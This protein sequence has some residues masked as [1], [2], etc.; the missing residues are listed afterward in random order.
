M[1]LAALTRAVVRAASFLVPRNGRA[2][3]IQEWEAELTHRLQGGDIDA[4]GAFRLLWRSAGALPHALWHLREAWR[5]D[6]FSQD[7]RQ[8]AR[9][10]RKKPGF[11]LTA[12]IT[13]AAGI[14]AATALF[15]VI[16]AV[17]LRPLPYPEPERLVYLFEVQEE[18]GGE[19][20]G[21]APANVLDW[22]R[23]SESLSEV[24]AW[25]MESTT[26]LG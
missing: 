17:L 25:W 23:E 14:G 8:A 4:R 3:W 11:V 9:G 10:L 12:S 15:C 18:A 7:F 19:R 22:R 24:A 1:M 21:P 5:W 20:H 13:F 16:E 2:R 26:L 6:S